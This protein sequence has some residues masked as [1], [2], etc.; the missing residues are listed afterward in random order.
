[1]YSSASK[2]WLA[3]TPTTVPGE[4]LLICNQC[5]TG[6]YTQSP[7]RSSNSNRFPS[8]SRV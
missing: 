2:G 7:T 1:M 5:L 6:M 3:N 4:K 8:A